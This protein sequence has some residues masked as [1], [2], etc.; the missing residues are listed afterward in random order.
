[1]DYGLVLQIIVI[2]AGVL[3]LVADITLLAKR[4]LSEPISI[5]WGFVAIIFVLGGII[6]RP[7]GWT[8]YLSE[9]GLILV[10]LIGF[11]L[12]YGLFLAS[13][14]IS[15]IMRKQTEMAMDISLLNQEIVELK[16]DIADREKEILLLINGEEEKEVD[17]K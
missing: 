6:L 2:C 8:T 9:V 7:S 11:C 16:K 13:C 14:H 4:R 1:M 3:I 15:E 12:I 5:T 17:K 10:L